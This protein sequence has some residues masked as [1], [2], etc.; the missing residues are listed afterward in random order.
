[1]EG[2][3]TFSARFREFVRAR[4]LLRTG[5][6]L[7]V[8][9]SGGVD[10]VALLH[11]L[12][13]EEARSVLHI[14]VAHFNHG[15]RPG[16]AEE[17]AAF[18]TRLSEGMGFPVV[19]GRGPVADE[20]R[21]A[22]RGLEDAART[23]RYAFLEE[24]RSSTRSDRI[25]TGHTADDNVE[26]VLLNLFRGSGV[27]GLAGIP[28]SR[29]GGRIIRP[30]LFA[31]REE[32]MEYAGTEH[33]EWREDAS[34]TSD[35]HR[36]NIIRHDLLPTVRE[37]INPGV[38][39]TISR[40]AE[41]FG[42]LDEYLTGIAHAALEQVVCCRNGQE[43][44]LSCSRLLSHPTV[45]QHLAVQLAVEE[46]IGRRLVSDRVA[47]LAALA[48]QQPGR[49]VELS[50]NWKATRTGDEIV[51]ATTNPPQPFFESVKPGIPCDFPGGR[52]VV[53]V[54]ERPA[55]PA[56]HDRT[57]E[58]VDADRA[59]TEG[60]VARSWHEGDVC[61]PLGMTGHKNVSDLLNEAGIPS[62]RKAGHPLLTTAEG[63]IVWVCGIR[64]GERFRVT[65]AT[66]R[67][68]QLTYQQTIKEP[69]GEATEDQW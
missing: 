68:L 18:V 15:L 55:D 35:A 56:N 62:L 17:D 64:I 23:L 31:T 57:M 29:N 47:A 61:T 5:D 42:G 27:R 45:V 33:L 25:V 50:G 54:V 43:V 14:T 21:R 10:S 9:V 40:T 36:R 69:H 28:V 24:V 19:V 4:G 51:I 11:L 1:M 58:Y 39:R 44:R 53:A 20:A 12:A 16:A 48:H 7:V 32:I 38:A 34:N 8:A 46:S 30:L 67:V 37:K 49:S 59:G 63:E 41:L 6:R 26:T 2:S 22:G 13:E 65:D 3:T 60:L 66:R 52:I